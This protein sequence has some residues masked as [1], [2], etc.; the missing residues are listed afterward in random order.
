MI[1][2]LVAVSFAG[3][4]PVPVTARTLLGNVVGSVAKSLELQSA[5]TKSLIS[6]RNASS[7]AGAAANIVAADCFVHQHTYATASL[8]ADRPPERAL[9]DALY[10]DDYGNPPNETD[11]GSAEQGPVY[12][13]DYGSPTNETFA[14]L[15]LQNSGG[16]RK[17]MAPGQNKKHRMYCP[18]DFVSAVQQN[19]VVDLVQNISQGLDNVTD[20][21]L[22]AQGTAVA[23]AVA[24]TLDG[25]EAVALAY[26]AA[27]C[28]QGETASAFSDAFVVTI[29]CEEATGCQVLAMAH[30]TASAQCSAIGGEVYSGATASSTSYAALLGHCKLLPGSANR[31]QDVQV[32]AD[33]NLD[34]T[35]QALRKMLPKGAQRICRKVCNR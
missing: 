4:N 30:S 7:A 18:Q 13:D 26:A 28:E 21:V 24:G 10:V 11:A 9:Q 33:W 15:T 29:F 31:L 20:G 35:R 1:C 17:L 14:N 16:S 32:P 12:V 34:I 6:F 3:N 23:E 5:T 19:Q 8:D 25:Q 27:L 2:L 22:W